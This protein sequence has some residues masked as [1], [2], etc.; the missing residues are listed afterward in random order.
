MAVV[1]TRAI[2]AGVMIARCA[3]RT[4][5]PNRSFR[6]GLTANEKSDRRPGRELAVAINIPS[7]TLDNLRF[8]NKHRTQ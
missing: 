6:E 2:A 1:S 5:D 3:R 7:A 4:S 8:A